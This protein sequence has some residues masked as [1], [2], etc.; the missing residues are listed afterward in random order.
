MKDPLTQLRIDE[1]LDCLADRTPTPG[2]GGVAA[3][4]GALGSAQARMVAAYSVNSKTDGATR[5]RIESAAAELRAT[6]EIQRALVSQDAKA[7]AALGDARR[8]AKDDS[9]RRDAYLQAVLK[10]IGVPMEIAAVAARSLQ[11][12]NDMKEVAGRYLLSDLLV[13]AVLAD[14]AASAAAQMVRVN[15][16]EVEDGTLREKLAHDVSNIEQRCRLARDAI[17]NFVRQRMQ[18]SP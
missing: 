18:N 13:A 9:S 8:A 16:A 12:M 1:F 6:D 5:R 7:Y 14:S 2:G 10:A 11:T 4:A 3:L 15:L 17:E